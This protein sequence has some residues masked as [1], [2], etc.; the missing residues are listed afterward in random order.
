MAAAAGRFARSISARKPRSM[1]STSDERSSTAF[2]KHA[3]GDDADAVC[4]FMWQ[5]CI[6]GCGSWYPTNFASASRSICIRRRLPIVWSSLFMVNVP[7][8][9]TSSDGAYLRPRRRDG[10]PPRRD[11]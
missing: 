7:A 5:T 6:S 2:L 11:G 1:S 9:R 8:F 3:T 10:P 4:T